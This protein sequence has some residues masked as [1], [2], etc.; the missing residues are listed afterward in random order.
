MLSPNQS[1]IFNDFVDNS[2]TARQDAVIGE[3]GCGKIF[4]LNTLK[5]FLISQNC[6]F[7]FTASIS[8][9]ATLLS[10]R[11]V[12]SA[13]AV[14]QKGDN[15]LSNLRITNNQGAAMS[16]LE[17]LFLDE[18]SMLN[19]RVVNLIDAK[20]RELKHAGCRDRC[21]N[22]P[23]GGVNVFITGDMD[24][25]PFVVPRSSDM[26]AT[27]SM[28]VNMAQ[29]DH[30]KKVK[31]TQISRMDG[32]ADGAQGFMQLLSKARRWREHL[33]DQLLRSRFVR[34]GNT[35]QNDRT[36]YFLMVSRSPLLKMSSVDCTYIW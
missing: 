1:G 14:C 8:I 24:Q 31:L 28:F 4:L 16:N 18:I 21:R 25:V 12:H 33:S 2:G 9:V 7:L 23:F 35:M 22:M 27:T 11:M 32:D 6:C 26:T 13:F 20:L 34:I 5:A 17:F 15:Y 3:V 29:C 19:G 10:G 30:F 36:V